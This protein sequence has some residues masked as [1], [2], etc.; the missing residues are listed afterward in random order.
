MNSPRGTH[1]S[2]STGLPSWSTVPLWIHAWRST[3]DVPGF[4]QDW[5]SKQVDLKLM[6]RLEFGSGAVAMRYEPRR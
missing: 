4:S 5:T 6:G 3:A 2:Q 1:F